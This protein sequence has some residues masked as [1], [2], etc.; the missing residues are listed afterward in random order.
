MLSLFSFETTSNVVLGTR[1]LT[2]YLRYKKT[3]DTTSL[4][5]VFLRDK[6]AKRRGHRKTLIKHT[7]L[8]FDFPSY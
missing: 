3:Y 5:F 1:F 2:R 8:F 4:R 6:K 7:D